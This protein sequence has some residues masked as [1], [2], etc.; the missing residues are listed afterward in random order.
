MIKNKIITTFIVLTF[1][2]VSKTFAIEKKCSEITDQQ[3]AEWMN[4]Q[5][6]MPNII[7]LLKAKNLIDAE[8]KYA[9]KLG[10]DKRAHCYLGC[11]IGESINFKTAGFVAWQKEYNDAT[12]CNSDTY[13]EIA[14][15]NATVD[16]AKKGAA[17]PESSKAQKFCT[18][19][20]TQSFFR[21]RVSKKLL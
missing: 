9:L 20:C 6:E 2:L 19:Y 1:G 10:N 17:K 3:M 18:D 5:P 8:K 21:K 15:Y 11:R 4:K 16:G 12:D 14:D 7:S 13:F